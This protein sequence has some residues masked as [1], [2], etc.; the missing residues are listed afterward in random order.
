VNQN[1]AQSST[2]AGEIATDIASV[3]QTSIAMADNS[4]Q[5]NTSVTRLSELSEKLNHLVAQFQV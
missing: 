1:V 2:V 4:D 3:N 5:I